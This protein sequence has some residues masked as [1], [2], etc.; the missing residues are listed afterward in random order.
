VNSI[1][2]RFGG[3]GHHEAAGARITGESHEIE[4]KVLAAVGAALQQAGL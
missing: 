2:R 3:G 1:A 4:A